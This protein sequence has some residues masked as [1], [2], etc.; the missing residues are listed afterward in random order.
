MFLMVK[1]MFKSRIAVA[2]G[3]FNNKFLSYRQTGLNSKAETSKVLYFERSFV[4]YCKL[5]TLESISEI[6]GKF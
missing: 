3:A 4:W 5:D 2:K 6:S 1:R